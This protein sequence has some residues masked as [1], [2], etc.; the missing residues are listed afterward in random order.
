M[1]LSRNITYSERIFEKCMAQQNRS[2]IEWFSLVVF[3]LCVCPNSLK[4]KCTHSRQVSFSLSLSVIC[5]YLSSVQAR[6]LNC[7]DFCASILIQS[8]QSKFNCLNIPAWWIWL[9]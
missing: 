6:E 1:K 4:R 2:Q 7:F 5:V 3:V 8:S 9:T